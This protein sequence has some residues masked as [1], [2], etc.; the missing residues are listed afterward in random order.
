MVQFSIYLGKVNDFNN[1]KSSTRGGKR[2]K[3]SHLFWWYMEH[4]FIDAYV[5]LRKSGSSQA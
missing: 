4:L 5:L 2:K 3:M 1:A